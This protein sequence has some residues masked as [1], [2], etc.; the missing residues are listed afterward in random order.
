MC[1]PW[2]DG[3]KSLHLWWVL[4]AVSQHLLWVPFWKIYLQWGSKIDS[5]CQNDPDFL[6]R[7][8]LF[9]DGCFFRFCIGQVLRHMPHI[10]QHRS[11]ISWLST[12]SEFLWDCWD[13]IIYVYFMCL[14]AP[15]G[16]QNHQ[17]ILHHVLSSKIGL[18]SASIILLPWFSLCPIWAVWILAA[19][20]HSHT[21]SLTKPSQTFT[22]VTFIKESPLRIWYKKRP[23][24]EV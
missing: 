6:H 3:R 15:Q 17:N 12:P 2:V 10:D 24:C 9:S 5:F 8:G 13:S 22:A 7:D 11:A 14:C 23:C 19:R 1:S 16:E 4:L 21:N 20:L 18:K